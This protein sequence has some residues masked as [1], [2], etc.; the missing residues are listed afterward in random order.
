MSSR[1]FI[2]LRERQGLAYYVHTDAEFYTDSGYLTTQAGVPVDKIEQAIETIRDEYGKLKTKTAEKKELE[3]IKDMIRGRLAIQTEVSDSVASWYAKQAVMEEDVLS[4][5]VYLRI[6]AGITPEDIR[7]VARE[8]FT[9]DRLN[10]AVIGPYK[11]GGRFR[12]IL[13]LE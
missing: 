8:I 3:R 5:E 7:R 10:L 13:T 1:L 11:D 6:I 12:K 4:P 2:N 9:N